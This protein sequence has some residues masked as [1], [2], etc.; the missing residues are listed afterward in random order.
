MSTSPFPKPARPEPHDSPEPVEN[1]VGVPLPEEL[2]RKLQAFVDAHPELTVEDACAMLLDLGLRKADQEAK[3][4][5]VEGAPR[6]ERPRARGTARLRLLLAL[7]GKA[8]LR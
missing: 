6:Q 3:R 4:T 7:A 5:G 1:Y 2:R 8:P